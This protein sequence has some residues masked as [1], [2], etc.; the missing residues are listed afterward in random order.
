MAGVFGFVGMNGA[1]AAVPDSDIQAI[2]RLLGSDR[3]VRPMALVREGS[4]V[5]LI[6]GPLRGLE[7]VVK[8]IRG[9]RTFVIN[10]YLLQRS[11]AVSVEEDWVEVAKA[12]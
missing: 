12:S 9:E 10:L 5:R 11:V 3:R 8:E 4:I 1:P 2:R 6:S 7:G